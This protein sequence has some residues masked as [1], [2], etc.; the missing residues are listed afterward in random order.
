MSIY[1]GRIL[2]TPFGSNGP[3][4]APVCATQ[5]YRH[6]S[7]NRY[8]SAHCHTG[9]LHLCGTV[10]QTLWRAAGRYL[11]GSIEGPLLLYTTY[12]EGILI[13]RGVADI[14]VLCLP[15]SLQE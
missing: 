9:S 13:F 7:V 3:F 4:I 2:R 12:L 10:R 8:Y 14:Y 5:H 1:A 11:T 6:Y 15:L